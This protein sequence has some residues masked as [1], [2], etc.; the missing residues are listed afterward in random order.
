MTLFLTRFF[1]AG[2][3][4][5]ALG[6]GR[7]DWSQEAAARLCLHCGAQGGGPPA[8]PLLRDQGPQARQSA[9]GLEEQ[10]TTFPCT[11]TSHRTAGNLAL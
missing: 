4:H 10:Q 1:F 8:Q 5:V 11:A 7:Q 9:C 3:D 6:P 2:Q